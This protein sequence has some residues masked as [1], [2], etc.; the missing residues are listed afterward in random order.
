MHKNNRHIDFLTV[1]I[2][3]MTTSD[4]SIHRWLFRRTTEVFHNGLGPTLRVHSADK[5]KGRLSSHLLKNHFDSISWSLVLFLSPPMEETMEKEWRMQEFPWWRRT[6]GLRIKKD[7]EIGIFCSGKES[8]YQE[9]CST[10]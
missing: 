10:P 5:F 9:L 6:M 3:S 4:F 7:W 1:F 2:V 8:G